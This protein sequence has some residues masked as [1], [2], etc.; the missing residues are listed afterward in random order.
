VRPV[1]CAVGV[2][3]DEDAVAFVGGT[4][5]RRLETIPDRIEPERSQV[6]KDIGEASRKEAEG[7]L[8]E[9]ESGS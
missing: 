4:H 8:K 1:S 7:V 3:Q 6:G 5:V 9:R 2:G